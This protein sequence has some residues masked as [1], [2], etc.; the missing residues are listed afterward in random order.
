[1]ATA[2]KVDPGKTLG[3]V[4]FILSF[5]SSL[6]GLIV[7][8]IALSKSKRA[9]FT[10]GLALAGIVI[11]S[12]MTVI[13]IGIF[14][15]ITIVSYNGI[16]AKA[17]T[18]SAQANAQAVVKW[19]ETYNANKGAYPKNATQLQDETTGVATGISFATQTLTSE[20]ASPNVIA[21]LDCGTGGNRVEFWNYQEEKAYVYYTGDASSQSTCLV[22]DN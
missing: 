9:G 13:G 11:G 2:P 20:P 8:I 4:G 7:S 10:N 14:F 1:M 15:A 3:I 12:V 17:N 18:T 22:V 6:A 16:T 19:V 5:V 21:L